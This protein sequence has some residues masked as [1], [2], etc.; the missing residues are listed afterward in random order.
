[1]KLAVTLANRKLR[2]QDWCDGK[3]EAAAIVGERDM[4]MKGLNIERAAADSMLRLDKPV[5]DDCRQADREC[6]NWCQERVDTKAFTGR[7]N[8][9]GLRQA[10]DELDR[11]EQEMR[12]LAAISK[13]VAGA[14]IYLMLHR[15]RS[16]GYVF[17]RWREVSGSKRHLSWEQ[18]QAIFYEYAEPMRSWFADL[19]RHAIEVNVRHLES[20]KRLRLLRSNVRTRQMLLFA[21]PMK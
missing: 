11:L 4:S 12:R 3:Q 17:L 19:A 13:Q 1:M 2:Q 14:A 9:H 21:R 7:G 8:R 16:T 6:G 20:R 15:R 18:G 10:E 5:N